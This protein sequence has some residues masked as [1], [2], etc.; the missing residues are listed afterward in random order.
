MV[1]KN[2]DACVWDYIEFMLLLN[3]KDAYEIPFYINWLDNLNEEEE[4]TY[5]PY[6]NFEYNY[7]HMEN[8]ASFSKYVN[9]TYKKAI[10]Y[11]PNKK[12]FQNPL[13]EHKVNIMFGE[14]IYFSARN[15]LTD[16]MQKYLQDNTEDIKKEIEYMHAVFNAIVV[17][18]KGY[19]VYGRHYIKNNNGER[20]IHWGTRFDEEHLIDKELNMNIKA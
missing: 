17:A 1:I 2:L 15:L 12:E 13:V 18:P 9:K 3:G 8:V 20:I 11:Y 19:P 6:N 4:E 14:F 10:K 16:K 7:W 5:S